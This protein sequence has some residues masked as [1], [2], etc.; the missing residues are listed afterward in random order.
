MQ[1]SVRHRRFLWRTALT[2]VLLSLVAAGC[3]SNG[4]SASSSGSKGVLTVVAAPSPPFVA[5]YTPFS[6]S[7]TVYLEGAQSLVYEPLIMY[8]ILKPGVIYPWLATSYAWSNGGKALTFTIRKGV[9]WSDGK[10]F[11]AAD[12]AFTF[13]LIK[14]FP[15]LNVNGVN[16]KTVSQSG[17]NVTLTFSSPGYGQLYLISQVLM[18]PQ[19]IWSKISNPVTYTD[20]SPI[21]TGPYLLKSFSSQSFTLV[22]NPHYWMP[23]EPHMSEIRWVQYASNTSA[24]LALQQGSI[25]WSSLF[26]PHYQKLFIGADPQHNHVFLPAI[27][28]EYVCLNDAKYPFNMPAVRKALSYAFDR[29]KMSTAVEQGFAVPMTSATGLLPDWNQFVA[30]QYKS[31]TLSYD[32]AKAK[33]MLLAAGFK[34]GSNGKMLTPKGQ[35]FQVTFTGPTPYTDFMAD[36]Q[37]MSSS[38][39]SIGVQ[40]TVDGVGLSAWTTAYTVGNYQATMC[41]TFQTPGPYELYN[42]QLNGSLS[43]PIGKN[44]VGN[45]ERWMDPATNA[46]LTSYGN[47]NNKAIQQAN[48]YKLEGIMVNQVPLIPLFGLTAYAEY[49]TTNA[50]G[51]VTANNEYQMPNP[52]SP[53]DET[54]VLHLRPTG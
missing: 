47:T 30:P 54:V 28:A 16:F 41:G 18:V 22:K 3:S 21:G 46:A 38:L 7:S 32:P 52:S 20:T 42:L 2:I 50:T 53:W 33:S 27:G 8:N 51:W 23:G 12:V 9:Q 37:L 14:K 43:A 49:R 39:N 24:D 6:L 40:S 25:D 10:P 36:M 45:Y 48:L 15:A 17:D 19:H 34:M 5:G 4:T 44:A 26:E 35:P 29:S 11:S 13:Q 31:Q 1:Q